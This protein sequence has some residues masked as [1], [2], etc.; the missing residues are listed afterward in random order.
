V[1]A[2][3][4][5]LPVSRCYLA[6]LVVRY[7]TDTNTVCWVLLRMR[8]D[9]LRQKE[10]DMR[11]NEMHGQE[12]QVM[13]DAQIKAKKEAA[14]QVKLSIR[15]SLDKQMR[16]R[17]RREEREAAERE[18]QARIDADKVV[19]AAREQERKDQQHRFAMNE[20]RLEL[21]DQIRA[22]MR[23]R[24]GRDRRMTDLERALNFDHV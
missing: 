4:C 24:P 9:E 20:Y 16:D 10:A 11:R 14:E 21:E 23:N 15:Q 3:V 22:D 17:A 6:F 2:L 19:K 1:H 18:K 12:L 8:R 7:D 13:V 5:G